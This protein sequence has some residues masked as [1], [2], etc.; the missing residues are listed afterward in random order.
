MPRGRGSVAYQLARMIEAVKR[1]DGA[2]ETNVKA[3]VPEGAGA[4]HN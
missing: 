2:V 1:V 3:K 4:H